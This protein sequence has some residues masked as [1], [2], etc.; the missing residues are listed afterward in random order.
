VAR[1]AGAAE[2]VADVAA[3][4]PVADARRSSDLAVV[5]HAA[6]AADVAALAADVVKA[7]VATV[8]ADVEMVAAS[9][10]RT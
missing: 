7:K 6:K 2:A 5:A 4:V 3:Q 10:S 9:S 8:K 1:V